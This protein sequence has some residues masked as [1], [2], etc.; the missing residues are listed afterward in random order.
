MK[1]LVFFPPLLFLVGISR[2]C[3]RGAPLPVSLSKI[4]PIK[5]YQDL[6]QKSNTSG[7][8]AETGQGVSK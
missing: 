4:S 1:L 3:R 5:S 2:T 8:V 6:S 7:D